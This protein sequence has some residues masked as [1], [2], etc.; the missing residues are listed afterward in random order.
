[1]KK[2]ILK[3][4]L[5][6][7]FIYFVPVFVL[8]FICPQYTSGYGSSVPEKVK[9]LESLPSP[10]I[11]IAGN[12]NVIF[13]FKS[14][15]VEKAFGMPVVNVGY[16]AG[17]G[18]V[19]NERLAMFNIGKG[20]IVVLSQ[21]TYDDND[22]IGDPELVL[23]TVENH[24]HLWKVFRLKDYPRIIQAFP[25][26]TYK[27]LLRFIRGDDKTVGKPAE[28]TRDAFNEYGDIEYLRH[29]TPPDFK[30]VPFHPKTTKMC[31]DRIN[32]FSRYCKERGATLV[33]AAPP[34]VNDEKINS[35][36]E[37]CA[38]WTDLKNM[39]EAPVISDYK[40]YFYNTDCFWD[41]NAHLNDEGAQLRT[42]QCIKD[43]KAFLSGQGSD[44]QQ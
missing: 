43:L 9:R 28:W 31:M 38:Y 44:F 36:Q 21:L 4:A 8:L 5:L 6:V 32:E 15:L 10:K 2:F 34:F 39:S 7:A 3:F 20:D 16:H 42:E 19:V 18:N 41:S 29:S 23:L 33:I 35:F 14:D 22:E 26:Y 1:M 25:R 13:G 30:L 24:F 11:I 37:V 40:D 17:A 12:S 27:C